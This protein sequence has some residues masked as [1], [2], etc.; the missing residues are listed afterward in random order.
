MIANAT[1]ARPTRAK[2]LRMSGPSVG[3]ANERSTCRNRRRVG[4]SD[5]E[6]GFL[7]N[8]RRVK[9]QHD[10]VLRNP[11]LDETIG[12]PILSPVALNPNLVANDVQVNEYAMHAA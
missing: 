3:G 4:S 11:G 10:A 2:R 6:L 9:R 1:R 8:F 12:D 7:P 5:R